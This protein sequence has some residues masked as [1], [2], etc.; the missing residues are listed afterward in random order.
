[1]YGVLCV[2][3]GVVLSINTRGTWATSLTR[4]KSS[5][6][7]RPFQVCEF[8]CM[9][10]WTSEGVGWCKGLNP[11]LEIRYMNGSEVVE[12]AEMFKCE[13]I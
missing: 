11:S 3:Y 1:M 2:S 9:K 6:Q 4:E 10:F 8:E 13:S 5:N 7:K 12:E